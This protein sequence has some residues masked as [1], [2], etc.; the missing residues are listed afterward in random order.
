MPLI[1]LEYGSHLLFD[2]TPLI[3]FSNGIQLQ[4]DLNTVTCAIGK[5]GKGTIHL[6][7]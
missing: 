6:A 2:Q 7:E 1:R 3:K 5:V 4:K